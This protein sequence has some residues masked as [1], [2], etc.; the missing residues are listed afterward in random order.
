M[1]GRWVMLSLDQ[2]R[3]RLGEKGYRHRQV[4]N[5]LREA[6]GSSLPPEVLD[7][8]ELFLTKD[9][10]RVFCTWFGE[11]HYKK[12]LN[13]ATLECMAGGIGSILDYIRRDG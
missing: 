5:L 9:C 12:H 7:K 8:I 6:E 11:R 1:H 4:E 10:D 2:L 3:W 13:L